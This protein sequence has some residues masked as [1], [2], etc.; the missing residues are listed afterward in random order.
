MWK[1]SANNSLLHKKH[2]HHTFVLNTHQRYMFKHHDTK[3]TYVQHTCKHEGSSMMYCHRGL[4]SDIV[5]HHSP[6]LDGISCESRWKTQDVP[7]GQCLAGTQC[8]TCPQMMR[9]SS[10][11]CWWRQATPAYACCSNPT[12]TVSSLSLPSLRGWLGRKR[13]VWFIPLT[14]E[15]G[16]CR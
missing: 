3:M 4:P 6:Q 7:V 5:Q 1:S 11:L 10:W 9:P 15:C 2:V 14:Y 8:T 16:M 13:Q 12:D